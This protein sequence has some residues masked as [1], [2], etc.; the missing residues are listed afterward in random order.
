MFI[1]VRYFQN[2][3]PNK[4]SP[5]NHEFGHIACNHILEEQFPQGVP[6][7][8]KLYQD[9]SRHPPN[10]QPMKETTKNLEKTVDQ[11]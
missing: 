8:A 4:N 2:F 7:S 11:Q 9:L 3:R 10:H 1:K 6:C 5:S